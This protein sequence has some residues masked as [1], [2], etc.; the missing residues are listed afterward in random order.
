MVLLLSELRENAGATAKLFANGEPS[1]DIPVRPNGRVRLRLINATS[2]RVAPLRLDMADA[3][4]MAIDGQPAEPF[5]LRDGRL[6]LGPG[7]R[8]DLVFDMAPA[9]GKP[10]GLYLRGETDTALARLVPDQP[11]LPSPRSRLTA[12]PENRLPRRIELAGAQ[13]FELPVPGAVA[14]AEVGPPLFSVK[15]GRTVMLTL[16]NRGA[17]ACCVHLHGHSVRLLDRLDDGWKPFW[18]DTLLVPAGETWRIAFVADS[19]GKWLIEGC[20]I[21]QPNRG[22][23]SWFLTT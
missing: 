19:P 17:A 4:V 13:R 7:N 9:T 16:A 23:A 11:A 15:R 5:P 8:M 3:A 18:L 10:T 20:P 14:Q 21:S 6:A 2:A 1:L 22:F 12:L